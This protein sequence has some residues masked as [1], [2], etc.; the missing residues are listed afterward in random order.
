MKEVQYPN[1]LYHYASM[2][3]AYSILKNNNIRLSDITKSNDVS[4]MSILFPGFFDEMLKSYDES[5][6]FTNKFTYK[7]KYDRSALELLIS[8]LREQIEK[9]FENGSIATF[10]L[11]LS[12]NGDLLS[13]W[14]GYA[15]NGKGVS[16][17]LNVEE[18]SI[19]IGPSPMSWYKLIK[20]E[21]LSDDELKKWRCYAAGELIWLI[22]TILES[23]NDGE[24]SD[25]NFDETI[26]NT[27]YCNILWYIEDSIRFKSDGFEE[28]AEWRFYI[29]NALN[30][31]DL[32]TIYESKNGVLDEKKRNAAKQFVVDNIEFNATSNDII[33]YITFNFD[34]FNNNLIKDIKCGPNNRVREKDLE[35]FLK[36]FG[37]ENCN[38][39]KSEITYSAR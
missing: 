4:E 9:E 37:Y 30:K 29:K 11:C 34:K 31:M 13:Q 22:N 28:E 1:I 38:Y 25:E 7:L 33:S 20:V 19:F 2:E 26:Y 35:L 14:R 15:D 16:L 6:G 17:G 27:I 12:E 23:I 32:K 39:S 24:C 36:K 5:N 18:L 10:A 3:K 8:E 21:Y